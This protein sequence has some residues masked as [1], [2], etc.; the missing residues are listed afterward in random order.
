MT[1]TTEILIDGFTFTEGPRWHEGRLYFS[2][3]FTHRVLA[4]DTKG[5]LETIVKTPYQ[6]SGLVGYQMVPS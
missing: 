5:Q 2:D 1:K 3:F 4:V 6:P